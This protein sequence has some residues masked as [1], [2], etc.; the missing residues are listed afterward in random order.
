M[1]TGRYKEEG[2]PPCSVPGVGEMPSTEGLKCLGTVSQR[3]SAAVPKSFF[4]I[5]QWQGPS[6]LRDPF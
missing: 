1:A 2:T 3:P 4:G 5:W 6:Q